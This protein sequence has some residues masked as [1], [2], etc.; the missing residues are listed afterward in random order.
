MKAL[1]LLLL[2]L[3]C[4]APQV[5]PYVAVIEIENPSRVTYLGGTRCDVHG[6]PYIL[7]NTHVSAAEQAD[8]LLHE[9]EH[10]R[11]I[12]AYGSC[13]GFLQRYDA[14]TVF[15]LQAEADASCVVANAQ[16]KARAT[17]YPD[18]EDV[19]WRLMNRYG[20]RYTRDAVLKALPCG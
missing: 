4:A 20:A 11:Q 6:N 17:L 3:A 7:L 10:L 8:I 2:V 13:R 5:V 12:A 9:H 1:T 16:R 15:R 14:D 19:I 18:I